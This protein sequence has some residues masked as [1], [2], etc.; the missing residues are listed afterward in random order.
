M[1]EE[2][3]PGGHVKLDFFVLLCWSHWCLSS[4]LLLLC[5][6]LSLHV[7]STSLQALSSTQSSPL[8]FTGTQY[9]PPLS[10]LCLFC[11]LQPSPQ[12]NH[13]PP[14][15]ALCS[16]LQHGVRPLGRR[17]QRHRGVWRVHAHFW[18]RH[19]GRNHAH[20]DG[21]RRAPGESLDV[22]AHLKGV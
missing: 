3:R 14:P 9:H 19:R 17:R 12:K 11:S 8:I 10:L 6:S 20:H 22:G 16:V 7:L 2:E 18:P 5:S 15:R 1:R 21:R 13:A 4:R